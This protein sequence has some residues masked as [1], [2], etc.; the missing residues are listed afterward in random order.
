MIQSS[1]TVIKTKD[2]V[3]SFLLI[4]NTIFQQYARNT[5]KTPINNN[6]ANPSYCFAFCC[7]NCPTAKPAITLT[8]E[9]IVLNN[10]SGSKAI[11]S[12]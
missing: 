4:G 5:S 1:P 10:P 11:H 7:T 3:H 9:G 8:I 2:D 12:P 6:L